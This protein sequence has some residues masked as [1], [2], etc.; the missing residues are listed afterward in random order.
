MLLEICR[1][2]LIDS[3]KQVC[4]DHKSIQR[5]NTHAQY[6]LNDFNTHK[7]KFNKKKP[8]ALFLSDPSYGCIGMFLKNRL[9]E[10]VYISRIQR[11]RLQVF[12]I[13]LSHTNTVKCEMEETPSCTNTITFPRGAQ[14]KNAFVCVCLFVVDVSG[15]FFSFFSIK[16]MCFHCT[17]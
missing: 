4:Q 15:F 16:L 14:S 6:I 17:C 8:F 13:A 7:G 9:I 12:V 3:S 1:K 10:I 5:S 11:K 2:K